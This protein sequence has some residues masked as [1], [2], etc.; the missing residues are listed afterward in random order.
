LGLRL[1][2]LKRKMIKTLVI[3][4]CS[5]PSFL[6]IRSICYRLYGKN[7]MSEKENEAFSPD[8]RE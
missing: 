7:P 5:I 3:A 6:V 1:S 8:D 4:T 2:D